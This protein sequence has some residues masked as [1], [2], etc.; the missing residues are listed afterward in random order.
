MN[1][2]VYFE[3][4]PQTINR[5][6]RPRTSP[7]DVRVARTSWIFATTS[8]PKNPADPKRK[9]ATIPKAKSPII[10][11]VRLLTKPFINLKTLSIINKILVNTGS[12]LKHNS[13]SP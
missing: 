6:I 7:P 11:P 5:P 13:H 12:N 10:K 8:N 3:I 9:V 1:L 2:W 4:I